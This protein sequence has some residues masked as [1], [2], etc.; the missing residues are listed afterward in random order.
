MA[1]NT[2]LK[3]ELEALAV[4]LKTEEDGYQYYK[5]SSERT[6]H[7]VAK[8]FFATLA[9]D[10]NEH[11]ALIKEF[12]EFLKKDPTG[13]S[14]KLPDA[15]GDLKKRLHT[16]FGDAHKK[17]AKNVPPDTS[18]LQVYKHA[19]DLETKAANFYKERLA[20]TIFPAARKFY[21]WLFHFESY[22]YRM[23]SETLG[24]LENPEQWYLDYEKAIFEG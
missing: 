23:L 9:Q 18:I 16:I 11:I 5:D 13:G 17:I 20:I 22:H 12:Y 6:Q 19:M 4:A 15:P 2:A 8:K 1:E 14:V 24:Y 21:D 10:E 7:P 3:E